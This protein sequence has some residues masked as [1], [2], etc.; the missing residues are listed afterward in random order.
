MFKPLLYTPFNCN[1]I[2]ELNIYFFLYYVISCYVPFKRT[3]CPGPQCFPNTL[4]LPHCCIVAMLQSFHTEN[5]LP[6]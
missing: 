5:I 3:K 2:L 4:L 6:R 1:L